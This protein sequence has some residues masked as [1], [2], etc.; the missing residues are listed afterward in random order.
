MDEQKQIE[1]WNIGGTNYVGVIEAARYLHI[2]LTRL[3][4]LALVAQIQYK[5]F[6][7]R[8]VMIEWSSLK[9][10]EAAHNSDKAGNSPR[11]VDSSLEL[12]PTG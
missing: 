8:R 10:Y 12:E 2:S 9:R 1:I 4:H 5:L 7:P 3:Y 6:K 11:A